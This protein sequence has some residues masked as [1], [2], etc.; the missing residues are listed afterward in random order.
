MSA[1]FYLMIEKTTQHKISIG[2]N[3]KYAINR[4]IRTTE[5]WVI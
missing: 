1:V 4:N 3:S 5:K 2:K